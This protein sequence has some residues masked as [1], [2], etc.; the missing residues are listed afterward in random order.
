MHFPSFPH[1]SEGGKAACGPERRILS[2]GALGPGLAWRPRFV[3]VVPFLFVLVLVVLVVVPSVS[4]GLLN[5]WGS[6]GPPR[7]GSLAS[8]RRWP[9]PATKMR[10]IVE[11]LK[12]EGAIQC[13]NSTTR[14]FQ[15]QPIPMRK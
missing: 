15:I 6:P 10:G 5:F 2:L 12:D 3:V 8:P 4:W 7:W 13:S 1:Q 11:I 14:I 9:P